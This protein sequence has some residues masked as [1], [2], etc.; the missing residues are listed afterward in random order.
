[1]GSADQLSASYIEL[2]GKFLPGKFSSKNQDL[3]R[4][5]VSLFGVNNKPSIL[6][7]SSLG[8]RSNGELPA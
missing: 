7:S 1:L 8:S 5:E 4:D 6:N 2:E 3:G